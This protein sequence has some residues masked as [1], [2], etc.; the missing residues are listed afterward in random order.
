MRFDPAYFG[1][2]GTTDEDRGYRGS[3]FT[4]VRDAI[5][6]NAYYLNW[7]GRE[8][9]PLPVY[10]VTLGRVLAGAAARGKR[11]LFQQAA[12]RAVDSHADLRWGEDRRGF[13]RLLHPNGV[14]LT[15]R[16]VIDQ[17]AAAAAGYTGAFAANSEARIVAR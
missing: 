11:W 10:G 7:G 13:R 9:P 6:E 5:F 12:E 16:W 2:V 14:C 1:S 15:G 4:E 8:E 17:A 3:S